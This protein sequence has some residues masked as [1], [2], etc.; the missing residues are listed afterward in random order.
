MEH[1]ESFFIK[2]G[3]VVRGA[4][5]YFEDSL[6]NC[7]GIVHQPDVYAL[8]GYLGRKFG[9]THILDIGC[10]RGHKLLKLHPEFKLAGVDSGANIDYCR[11]HY[12]FGQWLS[13]DLEKQHGDLLPREILEK[14]L[15]VCSDVIEHLTDPTG[16]L[17]ALSHCLEYAPAAILTTPER[18]LVRG[19]D[20]IG[21]PANPAHVREWNRA[22]LLQLLEAFS[23]KIAFLG[24]TCNN[25]HDR[26]KKTILSVLHGNRLPRRD[27]A[28]N[29][30]F[31]VVA[32]M[33]AYNEED[34]VFHSVSRLLRAG[35][36]VYLIDNW[37]TDG[38]VAAVEPLLGK[39]LIGIER[40]PAEGSTGTFDLGRLLAR[41]EELARTIPADWFIHHD[42]DEIRESPWP[43]IRLREALQYVDRM[44][45][46]AVDHTVI[47]F[48]P[49]D[50][51]FVSGSDFG[52]YFTHWE[53]GR[54][55][56]H[57]QQ[58]KAWKNLGQPLTLAKSG[59]HDA[60][61]PGRRVFPYKFL[62]R[63]YPVRSH[64]HGE[65]KVLGERKPRFNP[66]ERAVRGWHTQY[67]HIEPGYGF[68]R[69][70]ESLSHFDP[71][72]FY[73]EYLVE[74]ISGIGIARQKEAEPERAQ[75]AG[76]FRRLTSLL[77][78]P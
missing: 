35:I 42:V 49:I 45:F 39:G 15:V 38:T 24:L 19:L 58:V 22:E 9:C 37:S 65:K 6:V 75:S 34:I 68:L 70:P 78:L 33:T 60:D 57:F 52:S 61:F 55:P 63:H 30:D 32:F 62:L 41:V 27:M 5:V 48:P 31:R 2:P 12:P 51:S 40:F 7:G 53:F 59:G 8:A 1:A 4:S 71:A 28:A 72:G 17:L 20:D 50:N 3:Y 54:R 25:D 23:F 74:R 66:E 77:G 36:E 11:S 47:D 26:E 46:N 76:L 44:G 18:D 67:N 21:P 69:A 14:T 13:L 43:E 73:Q 56:G 16:L 64:S 29:D 10:G